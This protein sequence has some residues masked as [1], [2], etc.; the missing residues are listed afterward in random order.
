MPVV[1]PAPIE[2]GKVSVEVFNGTNSS[3]HTLL[4]TTDTKDHTLGARV[5]NMHNNHW[6]FFAEGFLNHAHSTVS[7]SQSNYNAM[8]YNAGFDS[9]NIKTKNW[10][11]GAGA[12]YFA[13]GGRIIPSTAFSIDVQHLDLNEYGLVNS[14]DYSRSYQ[15]NQLIISLQQGVCGKINNYFNLGFVIRAQWLQTLHINDNYSMQE[16]ISN[17]LAKTNDHSLSIGIFNLYADVKPF[18]SVPLRLSGQFYNQMIFWNKLMAK[19]E[20]G[21]KYIKGTGAAISLQYVF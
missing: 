4:A 7:A 13:H 6:G 17:G 3:N 15:S 11:V 5:F 21:R 9:S 2:K 19:Y 14:L 1:S 10:T 12:Q 18:K 20:D 16:S 8:Y